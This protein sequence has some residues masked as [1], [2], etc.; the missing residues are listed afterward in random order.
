MCLIL[1][2]LPFARKGLGKT[3]LRE[4]SGNTTSSYTFV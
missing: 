4:M 1:E 3:A 2:A